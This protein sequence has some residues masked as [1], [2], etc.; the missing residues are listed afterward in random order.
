[1]KPSL[2]LRLNVLCVVLLRSA[3]QKDEVAPEP[4]FYYGFDE[5]IPLIVVENKV[6]IRDAPLP[7]ARSL[8]ILLCNART[9]AG[10]VASHPLCQVDGGTEAGITDEVL[11]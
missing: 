8:R 9:E 4:H 6:I 7:T 3:C 10:V 5:K 1:M 11:I 2:R